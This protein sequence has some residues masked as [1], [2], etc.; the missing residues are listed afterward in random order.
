MNPPT[1]DIFEWVWVEPAEPDAPQLVRVQWR[2]TGQDDRLVQVYVDGRPYAVNPFAVV[3]EMYLELDRSVDHWIELLAVDAGDACRDLSNRLSALGVRPVNQASLALVRD[4]RLDASA[5]VTVTVDGQVRHVGPM[6]GG[7][8]SRAGFGGLFGVGEF[9]RDAATGPGVGID[10]FGAG[11]F[12][13][14]GTSWHW[15]GAAPAGVSE[16]D[17][18][19]HDAGG[20]E[21]GRLTEPVTVTTDR[22]PRPASQFKHSTGP[23]GLTLHW[24]P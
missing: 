2:T 21:I 14:G 16:I 17:A 15:R 20:H 10:V 4:E 12:G 11:A 9:G 18:I 24:T 19:V 23:T 3:D 1:Q 5:R 22:L 7:A 8:D 6:W 13:A